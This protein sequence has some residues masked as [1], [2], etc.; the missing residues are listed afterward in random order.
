MPFASLLLYHGEIGIH[1]GRKHGFRDV[2]GYRTL[3]DLPFLNLANKVRDAYQEQKVPSHSGWP[4]QK[5]AL[6]W[7]VD[8][9]KEGI[10]N[11]K[12]EVKIRPNRGDRFY[13]LSGNH[14]CLALYILGDNE[15][16]AKVKSQYEPY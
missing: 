13:L 16:R 5:E 4:A 12:D 14:R 1:R 3:R 15:V 11:L 10:Y 6:K 2:F 7:L 9:G 8:L